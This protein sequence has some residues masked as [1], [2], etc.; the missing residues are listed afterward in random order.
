M[1]S[2]NFKAIPEGRVII[3]LTLQLMSQPSKA[4]LPKF[5]QK[6]SHGNLT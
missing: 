6:T 4:K 2:F 3:N 5:L 1:L